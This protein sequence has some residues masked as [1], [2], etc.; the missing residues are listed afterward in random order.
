MAV[1]KIKRIYIPEKHSDFWDWKR[2]G[3][4]KA[5]IRP[6]ISANNNIKL[7]ATRYYN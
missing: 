1:A 4:F 7:N 3:L 2:E 6:L 5:V